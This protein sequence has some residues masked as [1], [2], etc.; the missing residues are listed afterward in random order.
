MSFI[1]H[2]LEA[3][4]TNPDVK[5]VYISRF[6]VKTEPADARETKGR[7]T[8]PAAWE[9]AEKAG[10]SAGCG[11]HGQH[12]IQVLGPDVEAALPF[13]Y[14]VYRAAYSARDTKVCEAR[15]AINWRRRA[16]ANEAIRL[17]NESAEGQEMQAKLIA[18]EAERASLN[19]VSPPDWYTKGQ[20][21][22]VREEDA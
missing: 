14:K 5:R 21:F 16:V 4:R 7:R 18:A 1:D 12:Q 20:W 19:H 11:N 15:E 22:E 13:D 9:I 2:I 10:I 8:W 17:W 6:E 3:A